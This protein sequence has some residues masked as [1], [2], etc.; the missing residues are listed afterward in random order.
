MQIQTPWRDPPIQCVRELEEV[1]LSWS[2]AINQREKN[3]NNVGFLDQLNL[4]FT[5]KFSFFP[6]NKQ[7]SCSSFQISMFALILA[8]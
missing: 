6:F 4:D 1:L 2:F 8:Y 7:A 5:V 3:N